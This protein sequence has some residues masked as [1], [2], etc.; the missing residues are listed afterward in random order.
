MSQRPTIG[1]VIPTLNCATL[2]EEHLDAMELWLDAVEEV[3]VVDS[4]SSDGTWDMLR[5]RLAGPKT[6][7]HQTPKGLYQAWNHGARHLSSELLYFSTVGDH[8]TRDGLECLR[9]IAHK[10]S[11]DVVISPPAFVEED[12]APM[13]NPPHWPIHEFIETLGIKEPTLIDSWTLLLFSLENPVD[14][15][16]G[17]S[18]SNIYRTESIQGRPFPIDCGSVGDGAWGLGNLFDFNLAATPECF[19]IFRKHEKSYSLDTQNSL[20]LGSK[21]FGL[22]VRRL[23]SI[24]QASS[25]HRNRADALGCRELAEL[26]QQRMMWQGELEKARRAAVPWL[27]NPVAWHSRKMRNHCRKRARE[28]RDAALRKLPIL[29]G[30]KPALVVA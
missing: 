30:G 8:I 4:F 20:E 10:T 9:N 18:A 7:F 2:L 19:S 3:I 11:A 22:L 12:G 28:C 5:S 26:V 23:E 17:S 24:T 16:L 13:E 25:G 21:L 27:L 15:I 1:V 29:Y 6:S 14:A